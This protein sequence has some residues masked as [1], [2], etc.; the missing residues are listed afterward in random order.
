GFDSA[1]AESVHFIENITTTVRSHS[2]CF[3]IELMGRHAG[4]VA[5][6]A[7]IAGGADIV[8]L[9]EEEVSIKQFLGRVKKTMEY[10]G[11]CIAV[12]SEGARLFDNKY[13]E[14]LNNENKQYVDAML[15]D[16]DPKFAIVKALDAMPKKKDSF[17]NVQLGGIGEYF[18]ALL[19][20]HIPEHEY[21]LQVCGHAI[22]GGEAHVNDRILGLR[23]GDAIFDFMLE[24]KFG[25]YPGIKADKIVANK[26]TEVKG[27]RFIPQDD[28]L[29]KMRNEVDFF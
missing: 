14:T 4:W 6:Y 2:R 27:E 20:K 1:V 26:L 28:Q 9:P 11:Y 22:R 12:V 3:V 10:Q 24:G 21:R 29:Y 16:A 17:G 13:P 8:V 5:L 19:R 23:F 15:N 18:Y 7:G 25:M